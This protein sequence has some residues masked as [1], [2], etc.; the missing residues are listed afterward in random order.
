MY[1]QYYI[2]IYTCY[3]ERRQQAQLQAS[4]A[5]ALGDMRVREKK[6]VLST[7]NSGNNN[8]TYC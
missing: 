8:N 4:I 3:M 1:V 5:E 7:D 2:Y 6:A